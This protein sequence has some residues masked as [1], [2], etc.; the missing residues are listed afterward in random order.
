MVG[1]LNAFARATFSKA[2]TF[3]RVLLFI[4]VGMNRVDWF[5]FRSFLGRFGMSQ[6][7]KRFQVH[8]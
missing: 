7:P 1:V 5:R 4:S 6:V 8:V 3:D 2:K